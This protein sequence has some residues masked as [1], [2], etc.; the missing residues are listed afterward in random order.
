M[1]RKDCYL[2]HFTG[3]SLHPAWSEKK[4]GTRTA[5]HSQKVAPKTDTELKDKK[6]KQTFC[7]PRWHL[8]YN[9]DYNK[10]LLNDC[11]FWHTSKISAVKLQCNSQR[12]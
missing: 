10:L 1:S 4:S 7:D 11:T 12:Y 2:I 6:P 3:Y 5:E 8:N 9:C